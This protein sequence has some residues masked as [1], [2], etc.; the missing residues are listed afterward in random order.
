MADIATRLTFDSFNLSEGGE[1][2]VPDG[3][4]GFT[5]KQAGVYN[6]DGS[7]AGYTATSGQNILFIAEAGNSE[8][9]G[10][11]D[12]AAGTPLVITRDSAFTLD[13]LTLSS[14]FT[15]GLT[16]TIRAYADA[17]GQHLIG[18][19]TVTT[20]LAA[21]DLVSFASGLDFG[22]FLGATRVEFSANDGNAATRDYF[23]IDNLT[24]HL[25]PTTVIDFDSITL[26]PGS[27][28]RLSSIDGFTF[29]ETGVYHPDGQLPGYAV[30][31]GSNLAFIAEA[32]NNNVAGYEDFAAGSPV[33]ITNDAEF[34]FL[35]GAFSALARDDLSITVR[36]YADAAGQTLVGE[37][38]ISADR[39]VAEFFAFD[40]GQLAGL[41]RIEFI[42][43]DGNPST[44][45]YFGF[46]DLHFLVA[47]PAAAAL[48][49]IADLQP[50]DGLFLL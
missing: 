7:I 26:A 24:Y 36:G 10:Y 43:N 47:D 32:N 38:T 48:G 42:S 18:Q 12:A 21:Q 41:H 29:S 46:D 37:F 15:T 9:G 14:A 8:I 40:N 30:A 22:T 5:W 19:K 4:G 16:V 49:S 35:G 44:N 17:D 20:T 34:T 33:V 50:N 1:Q 3:Y 31:S 45:D 27:E 2:R 13:S 11:E 23:G 39:G 6:P 28:T 25:T